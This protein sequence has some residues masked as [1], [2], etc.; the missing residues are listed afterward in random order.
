MPLREGLG[1]WLERLVLIA[2]DLGCERE[3][4]VVAE[5]AERGASYERQRATGSPR[6]AFDLL[7]AETGVA[8][9]QY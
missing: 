5:L 9:P 4:E 8:A 1:R 7:L 2:R 3:I 6:A